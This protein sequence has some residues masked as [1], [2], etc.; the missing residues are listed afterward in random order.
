MSDQQRPGIIIDMG[1]NTFH[2]L[3]AVLQ[4]DELAVLHKEK[5]FVHLG[6]GGLGHLTGAAVKRAMQTLTRY[7]KIALQYP[8]ASIRLYATAALREADN[9]AEFISMVEQ[10]LGWKVDIISG[11]EEARL[12]YKG[13]LSASR[14]LPG[15]GLIM[16]IGGGSV[17][18]IH[19]RDGG[20]KWSNSYDIGA[21]VLEQYRYSDPLDKDDINSI[22]RFITAKLTPLKQYI[23]QHAARPLPLIGAS[24]SF[25]TLASMVSPSNPASQIAPSTFEELYER[26]LPT[27]LEERLQMEGLPEKRAG[28]IVLAMLL[29]KYVLSLTKSREILISRGALKEGAMWELL[30]ESPIL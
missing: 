1:S 11:R 14:T 22:L 27:T 16:D 7:K 20:M 30:R 9:T 6:E 25:E 10:E 26:L 3:I 24:G 28:Y 13:V 15:E 17:E 18:F 8:S 19:F 2:L 21:N 4:Q 12:I 29:C 5:T 23:A